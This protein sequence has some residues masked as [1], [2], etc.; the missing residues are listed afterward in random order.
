MVQG[1]NKRT[2]SGHSH[3]D[4]KFDSKGF[5]YAE[6]GRSRNALG[7]IPLLEE[8]EKLPLEDYPKLHGTLIYNRTK[9]GLELS[10][11][12]SSAWI[13]LSGGSSSG[14]VTVSG[15]V[16][17][18]LRHNGTNFESSDALLNN[19][20]DIYVKN[21]LIVSG[22]TT[23]ASGIAPASSSDPGTD[24]EIRR[25]VNFLYIHTGGSWA[26]SSLQRF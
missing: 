25:D 8:S 13:T 6:D 12:E 11:P 19:G 7:V 20:T 2:R 22:S 26:R 17:E 15:S 18:T 10:D 3:T 16:D 1:D 21:N 14:E 24:G 4:V 5:L 9:G 23:V